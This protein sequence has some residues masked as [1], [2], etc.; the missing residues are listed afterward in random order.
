VSAVAIIA[1]TIVW[2]TE[3]INDERQ[4]KVPLA[5]QAAC[6]VAFGCLTFLCAESPLWY[7]QHDKLDQARR[8]LMALRNNVT[9]IVEMELSM[10]LAVV[11]AEEQRQQRVRFWDILSPAHLKRTL[12]AGALLCSSQ[13][14]G[15]ILILQYSTVILVQSGVAN[16]FEITII[17]TCLQFLGVVIGPVF[18][19]KAGRRPVALVAFPILFVLNMSAGG[20]AAAGLTTKGQQLGL[21]AVFI[22]FAFFNAVSFQSL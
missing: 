2:A 7:I 20:L 5:I 14:G 19:D 6:P 10:G 17:I 12:T 8:T 21:A 18:V 22:I 9:E 1:T 13:V 15:Q 16:P 4:Y 11:R 3:K